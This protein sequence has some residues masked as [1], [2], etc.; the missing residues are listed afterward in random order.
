MLSLLRVELVRNLSQVRGGVSLGLHKIVDAMLPAQ[1]GHLFLRR[2]DVGGRGAN[3][4][5]T[6][7]GDGKHGKHVGVETREGRKSLEVR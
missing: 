1:A 3:K 2:F 6:A 7:T 5:A 4:K